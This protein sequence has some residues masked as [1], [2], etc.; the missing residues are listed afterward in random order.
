[1]N[2]KW[3]RLALATALVVAVMAGLGLLNTWEWYANLPDYVSK[4]HLPTSLYLGVATLALQLASAALI[5]A[6]ASFGNAIAVR[7]RVVAGLAVLL[8]IQLANWGRHLVQ[9]G[10]AFNIAGELVTLLIG[11][12]LVLLLYRLAPNNSSKPTPLRGAA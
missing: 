1:M 3:L 8:L 2:W 12:W 6:G 5:L 10:S 11:A 9:R 7:R 4:D